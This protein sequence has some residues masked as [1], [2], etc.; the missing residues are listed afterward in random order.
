MRARVDL[1]ERQW[2]QVEEPERAVGEIPLYR[3]LDRHLRH[4]VVGLLIDDRHP[5]VERRGLGGSTAEHARKGHRRERDRDEP[6]H[7]HR[8]PPADAA[9][10][11][12]LPRGRHR[13]ELFVGH[14]PDRAHRLVE[15]FE[16][17]RP[18]AGVGNPV[19][20]RRHVRHGLR[21]QDFARRRLPTQTGRQVER[22]ASI[23][24]LDGDGL[25]RVQ[26]HADPA[27]ELGGATRR[28]Q[29]D[30]GAD[31]LS[32][33]REDGQRLIAAELQQDATVLRDHAAHDLREPTG[34]LGGSF[35]PLLAR[36]RR[37]T[38]DV[39]DHERPQEHAGR[40]A[41]QRFG[42]LRHQVACALVPIGRILGHRAGDHDVDRAGK[43]GPLVRHRGR[44]LAQVGVHQ[45]C[46]VVTAER[47]VPRQA[48]EEHRAERVHV[49]ARIQPPPRNCSG[50]A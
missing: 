22:R 47:R 5:L 33:R 24:A 46:V 17:E 41:L 40:L 50:A 32:G 27:R 37:V 49:R 43:L 23:P 35:V 31:R 14:D 26:P 4:D 8:D 3:I 20:V 16:V 48:L 29:R 25:P 44:R 9:S 19:D 38:P 36:E 10:S 39:G 21:R 18:Q 12:G 15:S 7:Q 42:G 45:R 2:L 28:L 6:G 34:E 13:R 1:D 30:R 11:S